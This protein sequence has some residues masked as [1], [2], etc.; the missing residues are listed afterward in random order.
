MFPIQ[1]QLTPTFSSS[2]AFSNA[3]IYLH[4]SSPSSPSPQSQQQSMSN[5]ASNNI[6]NK[7]ALLPP[8]WIKNAT[9]NAPYPA[10]AVSCA[11]PGGSLITFAIVN[12]LTLLGAFILGRATVRSRLSCGLLPKP[13]T[14]GSTLPHPKSFLRLAVFIPAI[15]MII[16]ELMSA[17]VGAYLAYSSGSVALHALIIM[18]LAR[19]RGTWVTIVVCYIVSKILTKLGIIENRVM[20]MGN[21]QSSHFTMIATEVVL[22]VIG[23]I[24]TIY[25]LRT[26]ADPTIRVTIEGPEGYTRVM[27]IGAIVYVIGLSISAALLTTAIFQWVWGRLEFERRPSV[28]GSLL[29]MRLNTVKMR[30]RMILWSTFAFG[31]IPALGSWM[32]WTGFVYVA[33]DL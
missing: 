7:I 30:R 14:D 28:A 3:L 31:W 2:H 22:E 8:G 29:E 6:Q 4:P 20:W 24:P 1:P 5:N 10:S 23:I 27:Y 32:I 26:V 21:Y 11:S 18:A 9:N 33:R 25:L 13:E 15:I 12:L 19:P 17:A 16:L